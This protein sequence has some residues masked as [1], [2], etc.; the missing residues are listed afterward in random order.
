MT[1]ID[2]SQFFNSSPSVSEVL[3]YQSVTTL[4]EIGFVV[5]APLW[6]GMMMKI[7]TRRNLL[8]VPLVPFIVATVFEFLLAVGD[9]A[10]FL[11]GFWLVIISILAI[12]T[13]ISAFA[14]WIVGWVICGLEKN[15]TAPEQAQ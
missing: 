10:E 8:L 13:G 7:N 4:F 12:I 15:Y 2:L 9:A 11:D 1:L 6:I 3:I 5:L 14:A